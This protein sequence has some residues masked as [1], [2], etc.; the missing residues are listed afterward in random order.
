MTVSGEADDNSSMASS[1][2]GFS[3]TGRNF[4]SGTNRTDD[5]LEIGGN[6]S[7]KSPFSRTFEESYQENM[8]SRKSEENPR[9]NLRKGL[10]PKARR[11]RAGER[12]VGER[13]RVGERC[14]VG[15]RCSGTAVVAATD[16]PALVS[17]GPYPGGLDFAAAMSD[18]Q[19]AHNV[20]KVSKCQNKA[21]TDLLSFQSLSLILFFLLL[22]E[23]L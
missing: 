17:L 5:H 1:S 22:L 3:I 10:S 2:S 4:A 8:L 23:Y 15:E 13:C 12:C 14:K 20:V 9:D 11:S 21:K 6:L 18:H 16:I 19:E 7:G